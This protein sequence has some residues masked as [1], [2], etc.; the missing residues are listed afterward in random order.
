MKPP[1]EQHI[2]S[3]LDNCGLPFPVAVGYQD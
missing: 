2:T 3:G 1:S